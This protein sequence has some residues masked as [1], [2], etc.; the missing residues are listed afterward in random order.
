MQWI[1]GKGTLLG[2]EKGQS[3][4]IVIYRGLIMGFGFPGHGEAVQT[5]ICVNLQ[6]LRTIFHV[7]GLK[8]VVFKD[9]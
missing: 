8:T 9:K 5:E 2:A 6:N 7:F 3:R 1:T 4:N